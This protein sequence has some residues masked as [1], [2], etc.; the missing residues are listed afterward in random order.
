MVLTVVL[1]SA[2]N[3]DSGGWQPSVVTWAMDFNIDPGYSP[4]RGVD[5]ALDVAWVQISP[6]PQVVVQPPRPAWPQWQRD[7]QTPTWPRWQPSPQESKWYLMANF[8]FFNM[9]W[10]IIL[11]HTFCNKSVKPFVAFRLYRNA[12]PVRYFPGA[13]W[14]TSS[15]MN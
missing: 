12:E 9:A 5:M 13:R 2:T 3:M 11:L 1:P 4:T 7:P 15:M 8:I 10:N 6:W 14:P